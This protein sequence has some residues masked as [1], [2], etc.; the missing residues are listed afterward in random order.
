MDYVHRVENRGVP[1]LWI[2]RSQDGK[3]IKTN[4]MDEEDERV[5]KQLCKRA[6][7]NATAELLT[8]IF[9]QL[10]EKGVVFVRDLIYVRETDLAGVVPPITARK[11][12]DH[13]KQIIG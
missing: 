7:P 13:F 12:V 8:S 11:L 10:K 1:T 2:P 6:L 3:V 9:T 4:K 5:I